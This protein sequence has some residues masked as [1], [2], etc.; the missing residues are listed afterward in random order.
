MERFLGELDEF[1]EE[2][3]NKVNSANKTPA[4][5]RREERIKRMAEAKRTSITPGIAEAAKA[6][7]ELYQSFIDAGFSPAQAMDITKSMITGVLG[8]VL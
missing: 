8:E 5:Q 2:E 1:M 4:G 7:Y 3:E 6:T